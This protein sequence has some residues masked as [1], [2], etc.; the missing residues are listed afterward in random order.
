MAEMVTNSITAQDVADYVLA[1]VDEIHGDNI[2]NLKLQKLPC[3]AQ[4]LHLAMLD[5]PLFSNEIEAWN[6]GPVVPEIYHA[7]KEHRANALPRPDGFDDSKFSQETREILDEVA[8]I[9]GQYIAGYLMN[10]THEEPPWK[11]TPLKQV[12]DMDKMSA[13]FKTQIIDGK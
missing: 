13:C 1:S 12:I 11:T 2:T 8:T 10:L 4:G 3:Y 9:Y 5:T 7:Y 6:Y